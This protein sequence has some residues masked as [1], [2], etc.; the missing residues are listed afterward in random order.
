[1]IVGMADRPIDEPVECALRDDEFDCGV[2]RL[3]QR[4]GV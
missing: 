1:M 2:G 3:S 4:H